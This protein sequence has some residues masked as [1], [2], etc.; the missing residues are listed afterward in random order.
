MSSKQEN[1]T[2]NTKQLLGSIL[3]TWSIRWTGFC[4]SGWCHTLI[5]CPTGWR[6][7]SSCLTSS[8]VG[9][10]RL[11]AFQFLLRNRKKY[12]LLLRNFP[13]NASWALVS[14]QSLIKMNSSGGLL[15][16]CHLS[17]GRLCAL[18]SLSQLNSSEKFGTFSF[19]F[20]CAILDLVD[21]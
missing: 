14:L 21:F 9:L 11:V 5:A 8:T 19:L 15:S 16:T 7:S 17:M 4:G 3:I 20:C 6:D 1:K 12:R 13:R 18:T 10:G 2:R